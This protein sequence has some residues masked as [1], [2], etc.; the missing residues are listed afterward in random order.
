MITKKYACVITVVIMCIAGIGGLM[1]YD[2]SNSIHEEVPVYIEEIPPKPSDF[3][4][5]ISELRNETD[6]CELSETYYI[7]PEFYGDSWEVGKQHYENHD[8][9]RWLVHG[10]GA[11]PAHPK[12]VFSSNEVGEEV[13]I[14]TLYRTGWGVETYQ[15]LKLIPEKSKYFEVVI[16][17][18]EFLLQPTFPH[19]DIGWVKKLNITV[20][21]K[22]I[23]PIGTYSI[24]V[25]VA[26]PSEKKGKEWKSEVSKKNISVERMLEECKKQKEEKGLNLKCE[27]WVRDRRSRYVESGSINIG[28]RLVIKIVIEKEII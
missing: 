27:E 7:Q 23:P 25:D 20:R 28:E 3:D 22:Q 8:Y 12:A 16:N 19:F 14:C 5:I 18:D 2:N 6:I 17:P 11:Y 21:I 15:G 10:Y 9:S 13:Q 1:Y 24:V 26:N 4:S